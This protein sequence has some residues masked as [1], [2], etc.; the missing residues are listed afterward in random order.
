MRGELEKQFHDKM[1][2]YTHSC[3]K[4]Q[5][6]YNKRGSGNNSKWV[7][8]TTNNC[9]RYDHRHPK[10]DSRGDRKAPTAQND[11]D[12]KPCHVHGVKSEH[13]YDKCRRNP[14]NA[15]ATNRSS[16]Y[17]K[18]CGYDAHDILIIAVSV[19]GTSPQASA[20]LPFQVTGKSKTSWVTTRGPTRIIIL[21]ILQK[22]RGWSRKTMWVTSP[23]LKKREKHLWSLIWES[24]RNESLPSSIASQKKMAIFWIF[25]MTSQA[26]TKNH[27]CPSPM[28][29]VCPSSTWTRMTHLDFWIDGPCQWD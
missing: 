15:N 20:I 17:I 24:K 16:Y 23:Q 14:K 19:A 28:T 8:S 21:M 1:S 22:K 7:A 2:C 4:R 29:M 12:F 26:M 6:A 3:D 10:K 13:L 5:H 27:V 9:E 11:K 25:M 18:K